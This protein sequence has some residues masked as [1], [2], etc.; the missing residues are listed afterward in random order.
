MMNVVATYTPGEPYQDVIAWEMDDDP[1][2]MTNLTE[3]ETNVPG[4]IY[5]STRQ[6]RHGPR[7]KWFPRRAR[8][9]QPFLTVTFEQPPRL[10]NHGVAPREANGAL[11]AVAWV[12]LNREALLQFWNEGVYWTRSELEAFLNGLKRLP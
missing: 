10:I 6:G 9:D 12:E 2:D 4:L 11:A 1:V 7:V 5:V 3:E 8:S